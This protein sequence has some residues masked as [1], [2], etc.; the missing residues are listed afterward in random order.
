MFQMLEIIGISKESYS[1]AVK[2]AIKK[3]SEANEKVFWFEV[4]E[5]RGGVRKGEVEFQVKLKVAVS[6]ESEEER[7]IFLCSSC[8]R[9]SEN[10]EDL[11]HSKKVNV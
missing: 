1:E 7:G 11:C 4:V 5:Q 10:S 6:I 2:A 9:V 8:G 3:L